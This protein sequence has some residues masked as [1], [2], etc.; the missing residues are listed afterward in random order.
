MMS[1]YQSI[2]SRASHD[3]RCRPLANNQVIYP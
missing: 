3:I 1:S 2:A